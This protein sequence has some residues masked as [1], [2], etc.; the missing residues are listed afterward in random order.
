MAGDRNS[1]CSKS[2]IPDGIGVP[3]LILVTDIAAPTERV[4]DLARSVDV[5]QQSQAGHGERAVAGR[6]A[7]LIEEGET[8]TWEATHFRI[9]QRLASRIDSMT[10]PSHFRDTM[11]SGAFA[12]FV[13]DHH[14]E[15]TE[16]GTR[17]TD[18][19]DYRS[20]LG[21]LGRLADV[22][23]LER[24]MRR[25]LQGRNE[26]IRQLAEGVVGDC[27]CGGAAVD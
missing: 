18:I 7:G 26:V 3:R 2:G 21:L 14:F 17:M 9:R 13:H 23:F 8:V 1:S 22:L 10:K 25:L 24:Y 16:M 4:F 5:H 19:F 11:V 15:A 20:P 6:V 12:G 27:D